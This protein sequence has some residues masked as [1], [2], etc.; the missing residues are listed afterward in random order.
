M[1]NIRSSLKK[2]KR[3]FC[4]LYVTKMALSIPSDEV[5]AVMEKMR[6][7]QEEAKLRILEEQRLREE[8]ARVKQEEED[9]KPSKL[10]IQ[11]EAEARLQ[12]E[13]KSNHPGNESIKNSIK[14][15]PN[16]HIIELRDLLSGYQYCQNDY[17]CISIDKFNVTCNTCCKACQII[18]REY[19]CIRCDI[20]SLRRTIL[21]QN[22][23]KEI[24]YEFIDQCVKEVQEEIASENELKKLEAQAKLRRDIAE[25]NKALPLNKINGGE[26][27]E[28]RLE[29]EYIIALDNPNPGVDTR[30]SGLYFETRHLWESMNTQIQNRANPQ[31]KVIPVSWNNDYKDNKIPFLPQCPVCSRQN[32]ILFKWVG[33]EYGSPRVYTKAIHT[34]QCF[35]HT[36]HYTW[37]SNYQ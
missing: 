24:H 9:T 34:V 13:F 21:I 12:Y 5:K 29:I 35:P 22:K 4:K 30:S 3:F 11:A 27:E 33:G 1:S 18:Q 37:V 28:D 26:F 10:L 7:Q 14:Q 23:K 6:V 2:M 16:M 36:S 15:Y 19:N 31:L 25:A 17:K 8:A 32:T 20:G